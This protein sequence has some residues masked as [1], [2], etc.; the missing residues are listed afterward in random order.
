[1]NRYLADLA[2]NPSDISALVEVLRSAACLLD[3]TGP[4]VEFP[5]ETQI[6]VAHLQARRLRE[7]AARLCGH[8]RV[9]D[10]RC[11]YCEAIVGD[12]PGTIIGGVS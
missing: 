8:V 10:G 12:E 1:M 7:L 9:R 6:H 2:S 11:R 3:R 5:I 4:E